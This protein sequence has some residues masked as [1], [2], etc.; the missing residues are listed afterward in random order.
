MSRSLAILTVLALT[1][2]PA[3]ADLGHLLEEGRGHVHWDD[4]LI[5]GGIAAVVCG[6]GAARLYR[7]RRRRRA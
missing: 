2:A 6:Y 1:I 3:F 5:L 4:L 7:R